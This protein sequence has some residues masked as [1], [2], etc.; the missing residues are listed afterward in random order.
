MSAIARKTAKASRVSQHDS[1]LWYVAGDD[2]PRPD[3]CHAADPDSR[4]HHRAPSD[5]RAIFND[6]LA[7]H[8][9]VVLLGRPVRVDGSG[10]LVVQ[11][12]HARAEKDAVFEVESVED[13]NEVLQLAVRAYV[14]VVV[15]VSALA[16]DAS[17]AD[18]STLSDLRLVPDPG[19]S[20]DGCLR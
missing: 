10:V 11:K 18:D 14:Y 17:L 8:P 12:H 6:A 1:T 15:D 4:K 5:R 19:A 9:V 13:G 2:C 16:D 7:G 20:T 3:N